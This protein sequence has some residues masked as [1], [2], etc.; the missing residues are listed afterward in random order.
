ML[1]ATAELTRN[2]PL[3][4]EAGTLRGHGIVAGARGT[5][6]GGI[7]QVPPSMQATR[8]DDCRPTCDKRGLRGKPVR[9]TVSTG[10]TQ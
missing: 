9:T 7:S 5:E 3:T 1:G 6:R 10:D 2:E 4:G 8:H